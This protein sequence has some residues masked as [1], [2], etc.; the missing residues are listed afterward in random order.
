MEFHWFDSITI[1]MIVLFIYG[2][3]YD[4]TSLFIQINFIIKVLISLYLIYQFNDF[5]NTPAKFTTL[6]KKICYSAGIY[7]FIFSFADVFN[8][9]LL[10][11][12]TL[13]TQFKHNL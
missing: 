7:I 3:I 9:Y 4:Q 11:I 8:S 1:I 2:I 13:V 12:K 5:R 6:D 10:E